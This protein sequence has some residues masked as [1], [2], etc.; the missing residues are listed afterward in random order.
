MKYVVITIMRKELGL[1][2]EVIYILEIWF[3]VLV[4][5]ILKNKSLIYRVWGL[6]GLGE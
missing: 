4:V 6:I 5:D 2:Y 1:V 3:R